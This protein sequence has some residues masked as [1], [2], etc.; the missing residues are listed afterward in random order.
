[1]YGL[2]L[3]H[4]V[5]T[6]VYIA[7]LPVV[8]IS[9]CRDKWL[10]SRYV[11]HFL[12]TL[13][14]LALFA[15]IFDMVAEWMFW[16]EFGVRY[17]FIAVDYLVYTHEV[18]GMIWESFPAFIYLGAPMIISVILFVV[19]YRQ[20]DRGFLEETSARKRF[21]V[22]G[23]W[24]L[25]LCFAILFVDQSHNESSDNEYSN[26]LAKNGLYSLIEAF[27]DNQ[28]Q[29]ERFYRQESLD[30]VF[31]HLRKEL[32]CPE[33]ADSKE[34]QTRNI[35]RRVESSAPEMPKNVVLIMVESLSAQFLG[36]F[37]NNDDITPNLDR[38]AKESLFF[39]NL[40]ATGTRT[41]RGLEAVT[42]SLPPTPGRSVVIR[43]P[44]GNPFTVK[45]NKNSCLLTESTFDILL[46]AT[47]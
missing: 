41:C 3:F 25:A 20:F 42:L 44:H 26:E 34:K 5:V 13:Y 35:S 40:Y 32:K 37:G 15:L 46:V 38:L 17:N 43:M 6:F 2:G 18:I 8:A 11:R 12:G 33:I 21:G 10:Q 24:M 27:G 9:L 22:T 4:D 19:T 47:K 36:A 31:S 29:Y 39:R 30:V 16:H 1:M 14:F 23:G 28:I 45:K 7:A